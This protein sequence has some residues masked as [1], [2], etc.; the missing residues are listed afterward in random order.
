M[1]VVPEDLVS[2]PSQILLNPDVS[3]CP[4]SS[5]CVSL[6][7]SS[8][9]AWAPL[10]PLPVLSPSARPESSF[11]PPPLGLRQ[12]LSRVHKG[13]FGAPAVGVPAVGLGP[14]RQ[15]QQLAAQERCRVGA[16]AGRP[17]LPHE[18]TRNAARGLGSGQ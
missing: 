7:P 3:S 9:A 18:E 1:F 6:F 8:V 12:R 10:R 15:H 16:Q 2:P 14:A 17:G 4:I 13:T 5:S 11:P